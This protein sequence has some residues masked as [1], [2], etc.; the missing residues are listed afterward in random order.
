MSVHE[1]S[2]ET[3]KTLGWLLA[4]AMGL[5]LRAGGEALPSDEFRDGLGQ[6][7]VEQQPGGTVTAEN[8]ALVIADRGGCT[9]WL[10]TKLK[11]PVEISYEITMSA[12]A[13]VSDLNCF[14]MASDPARPDDLPGAGRDGKFASYDGLRTY[15]AGVGGNN[16][17]TT[18]F[19][20]YEGTG[21]RP[22]RPEHDLSAR[23]FLLEGDRAYRVTITVGEEGR[24]QF[25][26]DGK[27]IF[28]FT[29][30][31]PLREGWFGFRTVDSRMEVRHFR[32]S[33]PS[34]G[35]ESK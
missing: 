10:R 28:D 18:R 17:T 35:G 29:D 7:V 4:F 20:R 6:W 14:W 12:K 11:A 23:E 5:T 25:A 33:R 31:Q 21:A 30:P 13:R 24:V 2:V 9:V 15:Y 32:V 22:L 19:R 3:M 16:N 26:R 27:V 8:G 34:T 1:V